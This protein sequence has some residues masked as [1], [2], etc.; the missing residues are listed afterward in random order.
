MGE[1]SVPREEQLL[2]AKLSLLIA[3]GAASRGED[4]LTDAVLDAVLKEP[5][6]S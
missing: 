2:Y 3:G 1:T 6:R 4:D 5:Q